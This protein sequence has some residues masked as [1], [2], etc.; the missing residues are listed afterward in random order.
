MFWFGISSLLF[1]RDWVARLANMTYRPAHW[2]LDTLSGNNLEQD[3][4]NRRLQFVAHFVRFQLHNRL[5]HLHKISLVLEPAQHADFRCGDPARLWDFQRC[6]NDNASRAALISWGWSPK[7]LFN[8]KGT[9][10]P[11]GAKALV[12]I[13]S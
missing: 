2:N 11:S 1:R 4:R 7:C 9:L 5:A 10:R 6:K 13:G 3:T 12:F 8:S